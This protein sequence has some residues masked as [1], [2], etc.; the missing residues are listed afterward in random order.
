MFSGSLEDWE[1]QFRATTDY[2]RVQ[3]LESF[4]YQAI[5]LEPRDVLSALHRLED[6]VG[7]DKPASGQFHHLIYRL[8][9]TVRQQGWRDPGTDTSVAIRDSERHEG[10]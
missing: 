6:V 9:D 1:R 4:D 3:L 8:Q 5:G 2:G 10:V 7:L